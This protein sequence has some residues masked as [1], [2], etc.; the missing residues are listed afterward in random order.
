MGVGGLDAVIDKDK[1]ESIKKNL[2]DQKQVPV[3][4]SQEV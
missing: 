4:V 1:D 3:N 2:D